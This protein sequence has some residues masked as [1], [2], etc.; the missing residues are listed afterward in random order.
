MSSDVE[1]VAARIVERLAAKSSVLR[2][3]LAGLVVDQLLARRTRDALQFE[4]LGEVL[5]E[6]LS[7]DNLRRAIEQHAAS[8]QRQRAAAEDAA[9]VRVGALVGP[10]AHQKLHALVRALRVPEARWAQHAFDPALVRRLLG[11]VWTQVLVNFAKRLPLAAASRN[12]PQ[13]IAGF[14]TRS[15]QE[16]A[17]KLRGVMGGLGAEVE[18]RLQATARDFSDG[19][20]QAFRTALHE[21]L[22]SA[23]GRELLGQLLAG[24]VDH[25]LRSELAAFQ[26]DLDALPRTELA[27]LAPDLI[28]HAAHSPFVAQLVRRELALWLEAHGERSLSELLAEYSTLEPARALLVAELESLVAELATAPAFSDWVRRLVQPDANE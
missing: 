27:D 5:L 4:R 15:V 24:F 12:A 1:R 6:V 23:E 16:Q 3:E 28:A 8:S 2:Q 11:P 18:R 21:R 20:A 17:E 7:A 9:S 25:V 14:L 10:L 13:S 26:P 22:H 19:A